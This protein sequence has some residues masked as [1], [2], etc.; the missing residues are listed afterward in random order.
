MNVIVAES[1]S[2]LNGRALTVLIYLND[3][4]AGGDT[5]FTGEALLDDLCTKPKHVIDD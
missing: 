3:V 2:G 5:L 4:Q 1:G